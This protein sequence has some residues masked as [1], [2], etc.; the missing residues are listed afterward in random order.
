[1]KAGSKQ[2][3]D[4]EKTNPTRKDILKIFIR[5]SFFVTHQIIIKPYNE[6]LLNLQ[7]IS[8]PLQAYF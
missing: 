8:L 5:Q 6:S 4:T 1:V 7:F 3:S 2:N